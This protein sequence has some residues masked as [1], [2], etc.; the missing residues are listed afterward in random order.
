MR[1]YVRLSLFQL[2]Y[3]LFVILFGAWVRVTGSGAGCGR[4]WP[5]CQGEVLP[6]EPG[7]KTIIEFTHRLT[8][9][10]TLIL[11]LGMLV[12][13][14]RLFAKGHIVRRIQGWVVFFVVA[15]ALLG[16][17][18]VLLEHVAENKSVYRAFSMSLHL[19]NTFAL[20]AVVALNY[21]WSKRP[22]KQIGKE[23]NGQRIGWLGI[24]ALTIIGISGAITALG[25]T[26][27]PITQAGEAI[28]TGLSSSQ[29]LFVQ[30]RIYHPFIAVGGAA[31]VA[32][33][34]I[35]A[36]Q[37]DAN[38]INQRDVVLFFIGLQI[39]VGIVSVGLFAPAY[40]QILH[41]FMADL[42]WISYVLLLAKRNFGRTD[43]PLLTR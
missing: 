5:L 30:L 22:E 2:G 39:L 18:L 23:A 7:Y 31:I 1:S 34:A 37:S 43:S 15:E 33:I 42:V 32:W 14:F 4:H 6:W 19:V 28:R 41:L 3:L 16:A 40:M 35:R 12:L 13:A 20:V 9:G 38:L 36:A 27:F 26:L 21:F 24:F 8:S 29:H 17:G 10:L 11:A 25:D